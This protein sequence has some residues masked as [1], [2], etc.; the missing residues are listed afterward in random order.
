LGRAAADDN[1][2]LKRPATV[3][4]EHAQDVGVGDD[5]AGLFREEAAAL[6]HI[7]VGQLD[8]QKDRRL[9]DLYQDGRIEP[10]LSASRPGVPGQ[11]CRG[12]QGGGGEQSSTKPDTHHTTSRTRCVER[13]SVNAQPVRGEMIL[14]ALPDRQGAAAPGGQ[15]LAGVKTSPRVT[16]KAEEKRRKRK[17]ESRTVPPFFPLSPS[18]FSPL[19]ASSLVASSLC[20]L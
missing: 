2:N 20:P 12:Q 11:Q 7:A 19:L 16:E 6:H 3:G 15:R 17:K 18:I 1:L 8:Q 9:L 4:F 5:H 10:G 14:G 13:R